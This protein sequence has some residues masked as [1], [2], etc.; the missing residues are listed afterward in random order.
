M[1]PMLFS[2]GLNTKAVGA[3][4]LNDR[5]IQRISVLKKLVLMA[6]LVTL[7]SCVTVP[8][9]S[10]SRNIPTGFNGIALYAKSTRD[11]GRYYSY[12]YANLEAR[13]PFTLDTRFQIG[14]VSK[15]LTT[16]VVL[17]LADKGKLTLDQPIGTV[18]TS[19]P[20]NTGRLVTIRNLLSNTSGIP[21][22]A[23]AA[24]RKDPSVRSSTAGAMESY[25]LWANGP[26]NFEPGKGW[27][28]SVT[29]WIL[30][31]AIIETVSGASFTDAV[32]AELT[33]PLGLRNTG[34]PAMSFP[35]SNF[36]AG[37]YSAID[38]SP[39]PSYIPPFAAASGSIFSSVSDLR[40]IMDGIYSR[41][42]LSTNRIRELETVNFTS[43]NYALGGRVEVQN[44]VLVLKEAGKTGNYRALVTFVPSSGE[45][46]AILNNTGLDQDLLEDIAKKLD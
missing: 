11:I 37:N 15:F 35:E 44:D 27:D 36:D 4:L 2:G 26:L 30:V 7:T 6:A 17:R 29:N 24:L 5:H 46:R 32:R 18:L 8:Q 19:I 43:Q 12:G 42:Y 25:P 40:L 41:K 21:D 1:R 14:S 31:R 16:L 28:Y 3:R 13:T 39:S 38:S 33:L 45:F 22:G 10:I 9:Q 23:T 20:G 34:I